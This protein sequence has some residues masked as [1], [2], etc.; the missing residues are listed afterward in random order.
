VASDFN[1][2]LSLRP[3]FPEAYRNR[4]LAEMIMHRADAAKM[5][6]KRGKELGDEAS[7][8]MLRH[9]FP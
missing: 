3:D 4:G 5:D 6:W 9:Y 1:K 7:F 2:A 8:K